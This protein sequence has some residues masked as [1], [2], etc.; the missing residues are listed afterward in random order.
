MSVFNE[1]DT[2]TLKLLGYCA[3]GFVVL[4]VALIVLAR[5]IA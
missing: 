4:L 1:E 3:G 5:V 2:H